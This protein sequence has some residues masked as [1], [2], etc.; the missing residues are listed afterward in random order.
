MTRH[1][2][3][4]R[5]RVLH[6]EININLGA[7]VSYTSFPPSASLILLCYDFY[8]QFFPVLFHQICFKEKLDRWFRG[9]TENKFQIRWLHEDNSLSHYRSPIT[10]DDINT[11]SQK[12][13]NERN[14]YKSGLLMSCCIN[15]VQV[16]SF[17]AKF[18]SMSTYYICAVS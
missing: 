2:K 7:H 9:V 4:D 17:H 16:S 3:I 1:A 6:R 14:R 12:L 15:R 10:I 8:L 13:E 18:H 5:A 11:E